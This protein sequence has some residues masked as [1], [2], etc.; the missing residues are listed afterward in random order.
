MDRVATS[1]GTERHRLARNS[2]PGN[3]DQRGIDVVE[4]SVV[5]RGSD[6][7]PSIDHA[8]RIATRRP[9]RAGQAKAPIAASK[10]IGRQ[11]GSWNDE[12]DFYEQPVFA[13]AIF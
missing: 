6:W 10:G 2:S 1:A 4:V 12:E 8:P 13:R 5:P 3:R 7:A 9:F 11:Q